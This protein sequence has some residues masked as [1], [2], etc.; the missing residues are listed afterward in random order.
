MGFEYTEVGKGQGWLYRGDC[1]EVLASQP[2]NCI[3]AIVT[4]PPAGINFMDKRWDSDK[5]GRDEWIAWLQ[6]VMG[7]CLR[8]LKPGG[9]VL[10]WAIPRTSHWTATAIENAGFE[11]RNV[12]THI[13][14]SGFPKSLDVSKAIDEVLGATRQKVR[15]AP[16]PETSGTMAGSSDTRPW[17]EKSREAGY[18]EVDGDE[19]VTEEAKRWEGW[20]SGLKPSCEMWIEARKPVVTPALDT[21]IVEIN[22][23][24]GSMLWLMLPARFAEELSK[25]N[26]PV[27]EGET[28]DT[29]RWLV[30]IS[31]MLGSE[32]RS[33]V[34][35]MFSL[36]EMDFAL[37]S[38]AGLWRNILDVLYNQASRFTIE[39]ETDLITDLRILN[40]LISQSMHESII[41]V[42]TLQNGVWRHAC[43]AA[44]SLNAEQSGPE[45]IQTPFAQKPATTTILD[46]ISSLLTHIVEHFRWTVPTSG[47]S[48][49]PA[50]VPANTVPAVE[51]W[52]LARKP[53]AEK[54]IAENVM[55]HGTGAINI[56]ACRIGSRQACPSVTGPK[57]T[58]TVYGRINVPGGKVI[59]KGRFPSNLILSH[60]PDCKQLGPDTWDCELS[61]PVRIIDEQSGGGASQFYACLVPDCQSDLFT[62]QP[63]PGRSEKE[64]GLE[65]LETATLNRVNPGGLEHDPRWGPI[66]VKNVHPTI[67]SI[68]LMR[69]L[70][71]LVTP[72]GGTVLDP[73]AG[74]GSTGCACAYEGMNFVG[75]ELEAEYHRIAAGRIEHAHA[76]AKKPKKE[77]KAP[78]QPRAKK[79]KPKVEE[80]VV[81]VATDLHQVRPTKRKNLFDRLEEKGQARLPFDATEE[82]AHA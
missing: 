51:H 29:A 72:P 12:V 77:P 42:E 68:N 2:P 1:R 34:T 18:H 70:V 79:P 66:Q 22:N 14:G 9:H 8:V 6:D 7:E 71:R 74:S 19:P 17:I 39:T 80:V 46:R 11:V 5:G 38:I 58:S 25:L 78:K 10:V 57:M 47:D 76:E 52:V 3:D 44:G 67:K 56:D 62:Y 33:G 15:Y 20:G 30:E 55:K 60:T 40:S 21:A 61:C 13:N 48:F 41:P 64:A 63:K 53:I 23:V 36:R 54:N 16:R 59:T 28:S 75:I 65:S 26:P 81:E 50:D 45:D 37:L 35:D 82:V 24:L 43:I 32:E 4:D 27:I 69:Y 73:F 49:L 31:L